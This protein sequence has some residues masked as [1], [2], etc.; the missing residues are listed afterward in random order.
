MTA[1]TIDVSTMTER[2]PMKPQ[3]IQGTPN[4]KELLRIWEHMCECSM[5]YWVPNS[6]LGLLYLVVV[7]A[8]WGQF[9]AAA[10]LNCMG[11]PGNTPF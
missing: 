11:S 6:P 10:R 1:N 3:K 4:L 9:T 7:Q 2:F 5:T 8:L